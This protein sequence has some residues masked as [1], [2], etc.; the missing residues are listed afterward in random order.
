MYAVEAYLRDLKEIRAL[1]AGVEE[2]S[3]YPA[4]SN[5][6]NQAGQSLKPRVRCIM[7]VQNQ[8]AGLPD[9]GL[10][11]SDQFQD[12]TDNPLLRG[13]VPAR[14]V[15]E[16]KGAGEEVDDI[17]NTLQVQT[18]W[19]R[20]RQVL[21]TNLR[22][23]ALLGEDPAGGPAILERFS[24]APDE[25]AFWKLAARLRMAADRLGDRLLDFV[26]R[27]MVHRAPL[28]QPKDVAWLLASYAREVEVPHRRHDPARACRHAKGA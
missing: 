26:M 13:Q 22:E 20:Y 27:V 12:L 17:A 6:L 10:F 1:G 14:G 8:G 25:A 23:F 5:L 18:Y 24:L 4:L 9:G 15:V 2:L 11:A 3:Y 16:V 19:K 28:T 21:V 7:N